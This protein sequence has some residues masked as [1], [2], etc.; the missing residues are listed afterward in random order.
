LAALFDFFNGDSDAV[1][2]STATAFSRI[3]VLPFEVAA[4]DVSFSNDFDCGFP[5]AFFAGD[6]DVDGHIGPQWRSP[7]VLQR[8][9][10]M[11]LV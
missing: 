7:Q 6:N 3:G 4:E 9:T 5:L 2:V 8:R 11:A 10:S 1:V